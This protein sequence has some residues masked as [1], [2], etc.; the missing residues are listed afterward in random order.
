MQFL[1]H[2]P[3]Y[4]PSLPL[5]HL[6]LPFILWQRLD[7][8]DLRW[9]VT[10]GT[11][12]GVMTKRQHPPTVAQF[13]CLWLVS[14]GWLTLWITE[15]K[16]HHWKDLPSY[17]TH[18]SRGRNRMVF[19]WKIFLLSV[20]FS[21]KFPACSLGSSPQLLSLRKKRQPRWSQITSQTHYYS[22]HWLSSY[23]T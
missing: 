6:H 22:S 1:V 19:C 15:L 7:I 12:A 9:D 23:H 21:S 10:T 18:D 16:W 8:R 2:M 3:L 14:N 5:K 13:E 11:A 4:P 20:S 17:L